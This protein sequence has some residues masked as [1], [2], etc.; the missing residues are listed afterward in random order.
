MKL[1]WSPR[2][3]FVRKVMIV[4][5]ETGQID[6]VELVRSVVAMSQPPNPDVLRDNPLGKIPTLVTDEGLALFDSSVICEYLDRRAGAGLIPAEVAAR[7]QAL[8]WQALG[9]GLTEILLLW[10]TELTR[11]SG[12][13]TA[14]TDGWQ[15][16]IR[17]GMAL[18]DAE[19]GRLRDTPFGIGHAAVVCT[20]GQLDFR[21]S[22]SDWRTHF[23]TLAALAAQW[24]DRSSVS[25]TA[26]RNDQ[27]DGIDVTAGQLRFA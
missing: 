25:L 23:P 8:R 5:H 19:G 26:V 17:A 22:D 20:L 15:Q 13:W 2:S 27:P 6:D 24:D 11:P 16:K 4:L 1:H 21:W 14:V 9:D 10:R 7:M 3:P 12:T 18:L